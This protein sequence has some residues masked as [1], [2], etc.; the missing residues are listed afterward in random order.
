MIRKRI[1]IEK[2]R[3]VSEVKSAVIEE[4][5]SEL[6]KRLSSL[7]KKVKESKF[8]ESIKRILE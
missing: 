5:F 2:I 7:P 4:S 6:E 1:K 8:S 3:I